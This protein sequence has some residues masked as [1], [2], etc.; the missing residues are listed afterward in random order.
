MVTEFVA[1]NQLTASVT[2]LKSAYVEG[3]KPNDPGK[4]LVGATKA[5]HGPGR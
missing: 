5:D 1:V 2:V 3:K 4:V